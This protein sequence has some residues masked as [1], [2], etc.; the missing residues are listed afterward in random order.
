MSEPVSIATQAEVD[1]RIQSL[2]AFSTEGD[3]VEFR[4]ANNRKIALND[5][6]NIAIKTGKDDI[7]RNL[8][9][10]LE[11]ELSG[12]KHVYEVVSAAWYLEN[13]PPNHEW[14]VESI[15]EIKDK[16]ALIGS[17]KAKK[18][19][20]MQQ[21]AFCIAT[22]KDFLRYRIPKPRNV[23]LFQ[24][25]MKESGMWRR[26]YNMGHGL[27]YTRNEIEER[28]KVINGRGETEKP[29][30]VI[31]TIQR[32]IEG[33]EIKPDVLMI[34]PIYKLVEDENNAKEWKPV[35]NQFDRIMGQFG[36]SIVYSHHD[37][38][39]DPTLKRIED[40]GAGSNVIIRDI[41]SGLFI[42]KHKSAKDAV[43]VEFL[44]RN[45]IEQ[46][47]LVALWEGDLR[48]FRVTDIE[49]DNGLKKPKAESLGS[50]VMI[51][52][53]LEILDEPVP[54]TAYRALLQERLSISEKTQRG[55]FDL[56]LSKGHIE[57]MKKT[58]HG[59]AALIRRVK[60]PSDLSGV[61]LAENLVQSEA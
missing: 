34:D 35:L 4:Q 58:Q 16:F 60:Q 38:K 40:R 28:F 46:P 44:V 61:I 19:W 41:D 53:A 14:L 18:S 57:Q 23:L 3:S 43:N 8:I 13:I 1:H 27:G 20:L 22:G 31:P 25:E 47:S 33:L 2:S 30:E 54:T 42:S 45:Y 17:S 6:L 39:G 5:A 11:K 32:T 29:D 48:M 59:G 26:I 10:E 49:P 36:C 55:L 56:L 21:L 9:Q 12:K 52:K 24:H 37:P 7:A 50:P 15:F 51:E